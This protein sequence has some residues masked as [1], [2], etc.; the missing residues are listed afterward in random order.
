MLRFNA[1]LTGFLCLFVHVAYGKKIRDV[2]ENQCRKTKVAILGAGVAGITAAQALKEDGIA[3]FV[4]VDSNSH[5]GGRLYPADFGKSPGGIPYRVEQGANWVHGTVTTPG[6][7]NPIYTLAQKYNL[8]YQLSNLT[9]L[10]TY[11][12]DGPSDYWHVLE[13]F[14]TIWEKVE[15]DAGAILV[16]NLQDRSLRAGLRRAGWDPKGDPIKLLAEWYAV[17][18]ELAHTAEES[19]Q[20]FSVIAFNSTEYQFSEHNLFITDQRGFGTFIIGEAKE[21]LSSYNDTRLYLN[22]T[23]DSIDSTDESKV[24]IRSSQNPSFCLE[25]EQVI[26]TFSLGVLQSRDVQFEPDFPEWKWTAIDTM[27]MGIYT[28]IFFQFNPNETFWDKSTE[29][30]LYASKTRGY[31]PVWQ[32]LDHPLFHPGSGLIFATV[33]GDQ[34]RRI[35]RLTDEEVK[36]EALEVLRNMFGTIPEPTAFYFPRWGMTPW[37]Y[38]SFSNMPPGMTLEN[39]QNLRANIGRV[40]FAGEHVSVN[41]FGFLQGAYFEGKKIGQR[42]AARLNGDEVKGRDLVRYETLKSTTEKNEYNEDNGW[43]YDTTRIPYGMMRGRRLKKRFVI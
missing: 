25:A 43:D 16:D 35:E 34:S 33:V 23:I 30:F 20:L 6:A 27:Q 22:T 37:A 7:M 5:I 17:E 39:H 12:H 2:G 36:Q 8:T 4:I 41:Y 28:K 32:S 24:L 42:V 15:S 3:D 13:H 18:S 40:W 1:C 21:L 10:E 19:S 29:F 11:T 9:S 38:G 31:Y 26:T 14:E